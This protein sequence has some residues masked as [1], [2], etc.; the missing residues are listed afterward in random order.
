MNDLSDTEIVFDRKSDGVYTL[1]TE[2]FIDRPVDELFEF[3]AD[4]GNLELL[5]PPWV[6]FQILTPMPVTMQQG[7]LLDYR[8]RLHGVPIRWRTE[9][10]DWERPNRF[11]DQQ[12]RGPYRL[13]HHE[14]TFTESESGGTLMRD[15]VR[16]IPRGGSLLHRFLVKPDLRKIFSYRQKVLANRFR[17]TKIDVG[18]MTTEIAG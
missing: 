15:H 14:H 7:T 3:F 5:T 10:S 12:L 4:A 18:K 2:M 6:N 8:I 9:I 1:T 11:V 13:W 17:E 16:Y